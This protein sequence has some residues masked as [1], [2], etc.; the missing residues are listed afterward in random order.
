MLKAKVTLKTPK[1]LIISALSPLPPGNVPV[2]CCRL[3]GTNDSSSEEETS[4]ASVRLL[5]ELLCGAESRSMIIVGG[6]SLLWTAPPLGNISW[7]EYQKAEDAMRDR[8]VS[9]V[10][11]VTSASVHLNLLQQ[12]TV[13]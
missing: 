7:V 1:H 13:T 11:P 9:N 10:S 2:N 5:C 8:T 4:I 6:P 3:E 12:S